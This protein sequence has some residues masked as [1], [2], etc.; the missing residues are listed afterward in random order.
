MKILEYYPEV[1]KKNLSKVVPGA[2]SQ[3]AYLASYLIEK[4]TLN[5]VLL[6]HGKDDEIKLVNSFL[7]E[8]KRLG[9]GNVSQFDLMDSTETAQLKILLNGPQAPVV[10]F[11]CS[12]GGRIRKFVSEYKVFNLTIYGNEIWLP[13]SE[14]SIDAPTNFKVFGLSTE[15]IDMTKRSV[16]EWVEKYRITYKSEPDEFAFMGYDVSI[17]YLCGLAQFGKEFWNHLNN[18]E[19]PLIAHVFDFVSTGVE[20]GFENRHTEIMS[21]SGDGELK[22]VNQ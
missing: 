15:Y 12:D 7:D 13:L 6:H 17:F 16:L 10:I 9:G 3:Y 8:W 1:L 21:L 22:I 2:A 5:C 18:I 14:N 4:G 11:P 20:S 19:A